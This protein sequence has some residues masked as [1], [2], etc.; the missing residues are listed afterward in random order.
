MEIALRLG[1]GPGATRLRAVAL[2]PVRLWHRLSLLSRFTITGFLLTLLIGAILGLGLS[3]LL[4]QDALE[5]EADRAAAT[6][7]LLLDP[8]LQTTDFT[9]PL[10]PER[11]A[12]IDR[13]IRERV[14][15][16]QIVRVKIWNGSGTVVY[17]DDQ[18]LVGQRF[19]VADELAE[20]LGGQLALEVSALTRDENLAERGQYARLMEIYAPIRLGGGPV[21]GA[22]EL[23]RDLAAV[24]PRITALQ[25]TL[26]LGLTLGFGVLYFALFGLVYQAS[27]ELHRQGEELL[28]QAAERKRLEEQVRQAQKMEALGRMA[29][30]IAH[31]FNNV[32]SGTSGSVSCS[33]TVWPREI[34]FARMLTRS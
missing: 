12:A 10:G 13:L 8:Y 14:L 15:D 34:H 7:R 16:Q 31:D 21:V 2:R 6:V 26:W 32:L 5:E 11:F 30:S 1:H 27:R 28:A 17:S 25:H 29:G 23:Y 4:E 3:R 19:D 22:Y 33:P 18:A 9:A 24:T 20:A